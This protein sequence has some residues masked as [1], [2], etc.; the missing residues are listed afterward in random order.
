MPK[1]IKTCMDAAWA[2][3]SYETYRHGSHVT[4]NIVFVSENSK[5]Y[6]NLS[7]AI[8]IC[9]PAARWVR[10]YDNQWSAS[11]SFE[12][13]GSLLKAIQETCPCHIFATIPRHPF[14]IIFLL[15]FP[16]VI[17]AC[18]PSRLYGVSPIYNIFLKKPAVASTCNTRNLSTRATCDTRTRGKSKS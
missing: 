2:V 10:S 16:I 18:I 3:K 15:P 13:V 11:E 5:G 4:L 1:A 8:E 7:K 12:N 17:C 6:Q 14:S 9:I